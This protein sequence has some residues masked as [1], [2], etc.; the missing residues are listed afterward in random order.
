MLLLTRRI[1]SGLLSEGKKEREK[2]RKGERERGRG[3]ELETERLR[4]GE[5]KR[6][7]NLEL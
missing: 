7:L 3:G 6:L 4:D 5:T 2:G 1:I